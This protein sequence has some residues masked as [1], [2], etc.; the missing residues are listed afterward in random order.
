MACTCGC[1]STCACDCCS[2]PDSD[3]SRPEVEGLRAKVAHREAEL[4][5]RKPASR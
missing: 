1:D 3:T 2:K 4:T 5:G